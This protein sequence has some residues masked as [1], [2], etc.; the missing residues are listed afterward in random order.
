MEEFASPQEVVSDLVLPPSPPGDPEPEDAGRERS[1]AEALA[2]LEAAVAGGFADLLREVREK[3][4]LDRFREEQV[5]RLHAEL[6]TYK[7]DLVSKQARLLIQG[8][9]RLH[10]D[11]GR[12]VAALRQK[13]AEELTPEVLF[14]QLA[15]FQDDVELL[16]GQHGVERFEAAGEELDP[17]RQTVART[18]PTDDPGRAGRIAE[19]V[20]PGFEQGETILQKERV[21]VWVAPNGT[22]DKSQGGHS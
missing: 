8:I 17:R 16:L 21:A 15:D 9:V 18:V 4:A 13:P 11:V 6:Q 20:R 14:R 10:D 19:R 2:R 3:A 5:D 12:S 1:P 7:N 22:N